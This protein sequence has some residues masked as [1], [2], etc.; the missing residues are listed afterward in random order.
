MKFKKY[1]LKEKYRKILDNLSDEDKIKTV[2]SKTHNINIINDVLVYYQ[3][4]DNPLHKKLALKKFEKDPE[5]I[6]D[7][8]LLVIG[9]RW[10][11]A[12]HIILRSSEWS[13]F[14][15]LRIIKSRWPEGEKVVKEDPEYA[16]YY[17]LEVVEGKWESAE[18]AIAQHPYYAYNYAK[19]V[20]KDRFALGEPTI[21]KHYGFIYFYIKD[22]I[23]ERWPEV[24]HIIKKSRFVS[25]E[26]AKNILKIPLED[27][28]KE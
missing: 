13:Y 3:I 17:A 12:E 23:G 16:F 18:P 6:Y 15:A 7:Y 24:E 8:A 5:S 4:K 1:Q 22:V 27:F 10:P 19:N 14:Y 11:E 21:L 25:R 26:Y 28:M 20:L 9:D 2:F